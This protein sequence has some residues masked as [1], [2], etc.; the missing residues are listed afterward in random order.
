[1]YPAI[2]ILSR[3]RRIEVALALGRIGGKDSSGFLM[4]MLSF[5]EGHIRAAAARGLG[6]MCVPE[7]AKI[8]LNRL[9]EE[10]YHEVA[11]ERVNAIVEIGQKNRIPSLPEDLAMNLSSKKPHIREAVIKGL[12]KLGWTGAIEQ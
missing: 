5:E 3:D 6:I 8:L 11:E 10:E 2:D 4:N 12:G 1:M 7:S 9:R